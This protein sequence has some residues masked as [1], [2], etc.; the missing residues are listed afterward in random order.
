MRRK[1]VNMAEESASRHSDAEKDPRFSGIASANLL[2]MIC[3][4]PEP[5]QQMR[6]VSD[7]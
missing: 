6:L 2:C 3:C 1:S 5:L 4:G 7:S